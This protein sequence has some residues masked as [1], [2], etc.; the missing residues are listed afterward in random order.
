MCGHTAKRNFRMLRAQKVYGKK[1]LPGNPGLE[2]LRGRIRT[3]RRDVARAKPNPRAHGQ[4]SRSPG[5][6]SPR[7]GDPSFLTRTCITIWRCNSAPLRSSPVHARTST[8]MK[9]HSAA[10]AVHRGLSSGLTTFPGFSFSQVPGPRAI[11]KPKRR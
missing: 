9:A 1:A 10:T 11:R 5:Q 3:A 4:R 7:T 8:V 2:V 6:L